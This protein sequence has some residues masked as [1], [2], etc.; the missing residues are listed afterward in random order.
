MFQPFRGNP[1]YDKVADLPY[2]S[3]CLT[4]LAHGSEEINIKLI[5]Q[6]RM[7]TMYN[8][9]CMAG[10]LAGAARVSRDRLA[11]CIISRR[12]GS[13]NLQERHTQ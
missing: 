10:Q 3:A 5:G 12:Q 2:D 11:G 13:E 4:S 9:S 6:C 8:T 7:E 1:D